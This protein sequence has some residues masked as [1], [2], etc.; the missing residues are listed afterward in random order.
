[1]STWREQI[2]WWKPL[3]LVIIGPALLLITGLYSPFG[4]G[5]IENPVATTWRDTTYYIATE[6]TVFV[7]SGLIVGY[8]A[9]AALSTRLSAKRVVLSLWS[10]VGVLVVALAIL[11]PIVELTMLPGALRTIGLVTLLIGVNFVLSIAVATR[12]RSNR[13]L[14][15]G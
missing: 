14:H 2:S 8:L 7:I 9:F 13:T 3:Y 1:M 15:N 11:W 6:S 4:E 10:G 5:M 12:E